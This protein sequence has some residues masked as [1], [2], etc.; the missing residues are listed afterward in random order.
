MRLAYSVAELFVSVVKLS[1]YAERL[2][3]V[4]NLFG[5][6]PKIRNDGN[7]SNLSGS[8]PNGKS[9]GILL[10]KK[11]KRSLVAAKRGAVDYIRCLHSIV[12]VNVFHT[13]FLR[14]KHIYLNCY[15]GILFS[16]YVLAL[17][18]ELRSVE[19]RLVYTDSVVFTSEKAVKKLAHY[20]LSLVPLLS[21]TLVFVGSCGVPLREAE[22]AV[23]PKTDRFKHVLCKLK[24][25]LELLGKLL[26]AKNKVSLGN[27]ELTDSYKTM[28]LTGILI[29]EKRGGFAKAHRK[30]SVGALFVKKYLILKGA[31]HRTEGEALLGVVVGVAHNEHTV[32]IVVPVARNLVK[33]A[34]CHK[35]SFC[36][37]VAPL[38]LLVLN[39]SLQALNGSRTLGKKNR[40]SLT[41]SVNS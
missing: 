26:G 1:S 4:C 18:I 22:G 21:C 23:L 31:G 6:I 30:L 35:G 7:N 36:K 9:T 37:K 38:L 16:E 28:H 25:A 15:Y 13:E 5:I 27:C 12:A 41:D 39:P 34:L 8:K 14:K 40:K 2:K 29:S 24:A 32:K 10:K 33:L 19:C 20:R 3:R 11:R 17:N